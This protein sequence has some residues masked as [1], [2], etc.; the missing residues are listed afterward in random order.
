MRRSSGASRTQAQTQQ[1]N[2]RATRR[3]GAYLR[4]ADGSSEG[5]GGA[6]GTDGAREVCLAGPCTAMMSPVPALGPAPATVIFPRTPAPGEYLGQGNMDNSLA[7]SAP[8]PRGQA[9]SPPQVT[10]ALTPPLLAPPRPLEATRSPSPLPTLSSALPCTD[11]FPLTFR[12]QPWPRPLLPPSLPSSFSRPLNIDSLGLVLLK[13]TFIYIAKRT[14]L[15][16][17]LLHKAYS[18]PP[19]TST[20]TVWCHTRNLTPEDTDMGWLHLSSRQP[21]S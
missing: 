5:S 1:F 13:L 21:T 10:R 12:V 17:Q 9:P 15:S 16:T 14:K 3:I 2:T 20:H 7:S 19:P 6:R 8:T 18:L 4:G 11:P